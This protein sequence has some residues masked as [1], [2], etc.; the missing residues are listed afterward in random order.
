MQK[1]KKMKL[2]VLIAIGVIAAAAGIWYLIGSMGVVSTDDA[3]IEGRIYTVA[4]RIP[5]TVRVVNVT[6]NQRV[7]KHDLV[8]ELDPSDYALQVD[9]AQ[10]NLDMRKTLY[11]QARSDEK[12]G[13]T[14]YRRKAISTV[15]YENFITAYRVAKDQVELAETQLNVARLNL[16]YTKIYAPADGYVTQKVVEAG[17]QI[18][19]AQALMA[20]V[21]KD[22]WVVANYK[23]TDL[24]RVR[25]G[26][27]VNIRI[28]A[29]PGKTF[30][31]YVDSI[32]RGTGAAFSMFPPENATGSFVK[33][34]QRVPV[35]ILFDGDPDKQYDLSI[36]MSAVTDIKVR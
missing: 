2:T 30:R 23:E 15:R 25:P 4:S 3:Y 16:S 17:N 10:A 24:D 1:S 28:D 29:Y 33:V 21:S 6:D 9:Q 5:G 35:K 11:E 19:P 7:K 36:G 12:R 22:L 31:G 8:L 18:M 27:K 34:V 13:E 26:Q 32:Q 20:I 14:L